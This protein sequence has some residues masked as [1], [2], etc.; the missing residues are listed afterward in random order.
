VLSSRA[1]F[2]I[3]LATLSIGH[4]RTCVGDEDISVLKK[5]QKLEV[6]LKS[7]NAVN[8]SSE[9]QHLAVAWKE[10]LSGKSF[11]IG[12]PGHPDKPLV[13]TA[14]KAKDAP[15]TEYV[16][17]SLGI[18]DSY[19]QDSRSPKAHRKNEYTAVDEVKVDSLKQDKPKPGG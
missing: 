12:R 13:M 5:G 6:V 16:V 4:S 11:Y 1:L 15:E 17:T 8:A 2:A 19:R 18:Y 7:I 14:T 9:E 3:A 10:G